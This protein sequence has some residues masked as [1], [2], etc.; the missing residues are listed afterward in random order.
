VPRPQALLVIFSVLVSNPLN[1]QEQEQND[2]L[3]RPGD[4]GAEFRQMLEIRIVAIR[5]IARASAEVLKLRIAAL[6]LVEDLQAESRLL[7]LSH[8]N[9]NGN[10]NEFDRLALAVAS[11]KSVCAAALLQPDPKGDALV[12]KR[13]QMK[14]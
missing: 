7:E 8:D 5:V 4:V 1:Q 14:E 3:D 6:F 2:D 10:H 11:V 13:D 12:N 9:V